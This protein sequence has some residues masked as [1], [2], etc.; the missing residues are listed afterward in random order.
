MKSSKR[1]VVLVSLI[2][3]LKHSNL[4]GKTIPQNSVLYLPRDFEGSNQR[5][6]S[7]SIGPAEEEKK[8]EKTS[9]GLL[10]S[11]VLVVTIFSLGHESPVL[12]PF[13]T[14]IAGTTATSIRITFG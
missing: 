6:Q 2:F 11:L 1:H 9:G 4:I 8:S 5:L 14:E 3:L 7:S 12:A 13:I 10:M